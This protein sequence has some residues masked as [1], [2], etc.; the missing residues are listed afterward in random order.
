LI[1]FHSIHVVCHFIP[2]P[3]SPHLGGASGESPLEHWAVAGTGI[4]R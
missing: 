2:N 3:L 1:A 4:R